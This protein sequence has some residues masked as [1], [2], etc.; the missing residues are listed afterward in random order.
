MPVV[1]YIEDFRFLLKV[2]YPCAL[3]YQLQTRQL[4]FVEKKHSPCS[5]QPTAVYIYYAINVFVLYTLYIFK[6]SAQEQRRQ[7]ENVFYRQL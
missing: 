1:C 4:N 2:V 6:Y 7:T 5:F 3:S